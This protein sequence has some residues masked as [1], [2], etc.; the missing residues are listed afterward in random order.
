MRE[1]RLR[2]SH[3]NNR[4]APQRVAYSL[5]ERQANRLT[6]LRIYPPPYHV[7]HYAVAQRVEPHKLM[8]RAAPEREAAH[9]GQVIVEVHHPHERT[10]HVSAR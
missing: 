6:T 2:T 1:H 5:S 3:R 4:K 10:A 7:E 8:V 9:M